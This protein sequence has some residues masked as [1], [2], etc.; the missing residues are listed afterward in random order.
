[1]SQL[2]SP[3]PLISLLV[4]SPKLS[5][6]FLHYVFYSSISSSFLSS[7]SPSFLFPFPFFPFFLLSFLFSFFLSFPSSLPCFLSPFIP[8]SFPSIPFPPDPSLLPLSPSFLVL[9]IESRISHMRGKHSTL[10]LCCLPSFQFLAW[11]QDLSKLSLNSLPSSA[12]P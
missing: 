3:P 8:C 10:E 5:P 1:M 2:P 9:E 12:R 4:P 11:M 7:Y 6:L